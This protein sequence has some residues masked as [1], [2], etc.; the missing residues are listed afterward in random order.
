MI[1]LLLLF[2]Y[3][4]IASLKKNYLAI[5]RKDA[6]LDTQKSLAADPHK[7]YHLKATDNH[8]DFIVF[9]FIFKVSI[10]SKGKRSFCS[11]EQEYSF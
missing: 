4:W 11:K 6:K 3:H 2:F 8:S 10:T 5:L 1:A 7:L 9:K